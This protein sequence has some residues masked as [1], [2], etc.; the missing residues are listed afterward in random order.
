MVVDITHLSHSVLVYCSIVFL[1]IS[2]PYVV[3][4]K[5]RRRVTEYNR[6][7]ELAH[8]APLKTR[9]FPFVATGMLMWGLGAAIAAIWPQHNRDVNPVGTVL[10]LVGVVPLI[11]GF[12]LAVIP[13]RLWSY[14]EPSDCPG[15]DVASDHDTADA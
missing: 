12:L 3:S 6:Q 1:P 13:Y 4:R 7:Q 10:L 9:S 5:V 11:A 15:P 14:G 2:V 8:T